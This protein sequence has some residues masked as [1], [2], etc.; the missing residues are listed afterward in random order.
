MSIAYCA[1]GK[2]SYL[3]LT[4]H[5]ITCD[6]RLVCLNLACDHFPGSHTATLVATKIKHTYESVGINENNVLACVMDNEATNNAAGNLMSCGWIGC[7][8]HLIETITK[9]AFEAPGVNN[10][11]KIAR[12]VASFLNKSTQAGDALMAIQ[13]ALTKQKEA[14]L[15]KLDV[16]TRWW[17]TD[18]MIERLLKLKPYLQ[19]L[20]TNNI[21]PRKAAVL[22]K[23]LADVGVAPL[24]V[25]S[26]HEGTCLLLCD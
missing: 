24:T 10:A 16:V 9:R 19:T 23:E 25:E 4:A 18:T 6:W 3:G 14:L 5:Y 8:D 22:Q 26:V 20:H 21:Y 11:V 2:K 13:R 7:A 1:E 12:K 17:S 15:S